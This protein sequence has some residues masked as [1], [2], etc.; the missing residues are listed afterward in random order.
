MA[1]MELTDLEKVLP[2]EIRLDLPQQ[3]ITWEQ[4]EVRTALRRRAK[5]LLQL[6]DR[7]GDC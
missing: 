6:Q 5:L 7:T 1:E 3:T 4:Y 2:A